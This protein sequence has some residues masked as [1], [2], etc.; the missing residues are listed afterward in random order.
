MSSRR[1]KPET[2]FVY[3]YGIELVGRAIWS[4]GVQTCPE[5]GLVFRFAARPDADIIC[6]KCHAMLRKSAAKLN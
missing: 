1:P 4:Q 3:Q 5:C 6:P 2:D